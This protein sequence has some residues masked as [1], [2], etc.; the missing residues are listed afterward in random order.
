MK[1]KFQN[2]STERE[3]ESRFIRRTDSQPGPRRH[4]NQGNFC[5]S[6]DSAGFV[7]MTQRGWKKEE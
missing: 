4:D 2:S 6:Q 1:F 7:K 3:K 5:Q